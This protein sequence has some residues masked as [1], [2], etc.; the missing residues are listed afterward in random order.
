M[1]V[2]ADSPI[3]ALGD[4]IQVKAILDPGLI[5]EAKKGQWTW[6]IVAAKN[7]K[8]KEIMNQPR[9]VIDHVKRVL[10]D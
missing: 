4:I 3:K 6:N 1:Y 5:E 2:R 8:L 7:S 9:E 10:A